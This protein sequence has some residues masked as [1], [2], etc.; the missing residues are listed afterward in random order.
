MLAS[1]SFDGTIKLWAIAT[2]EELTC[3][4]GH[5]HSV[6]ALAFAPDGQKIASAS[7]DQ[8]V[9]VWRLGGVTKKIGR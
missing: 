3:L 7:H 5:T 4:R 8:T 1:G 2:G 6:I 9:R